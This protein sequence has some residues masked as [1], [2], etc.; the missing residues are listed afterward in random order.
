MHK[1]S[2]L[3]VVLALALAPSVGLLA[4]EV[5]AQAPDAA[6]STSGMVA[7]QQVIASQ[8]GADVLAAG[9][10]A[11]DA[12]IAVGFALAVTHPTA[13]NI[14]GGGFMVIRFPNG[15]STAIDFRE[16]APLAAHPEMWLDESGEYS[17]ELHHRSHMAVGVPGT[18]AGF[19]MAHRLYGQSNWSE[20]VSPAV[21]LAEEGFPLS[22]SLARSISSFGSRS[23]YEATVAAFTKDG[24]AYQ[25]GETWRQPDLARTLARIE[26]GRSDGFYRGETARLIAAEM[27]R[28]GGV[29]T[30]EDLDRYQARERATVTGTYRGFD[31]I[32]MPPPSSGG[33]A[34]VTMLNM[35]EAFDL[36]GMGHNSAAYIHHVSEAMRRAFQDRA[37]YLADSD[38]AD[39]PVQ[40][41][42][43]KEHADWLRRNIDPDRA[44][45]SHPSD[46]AMAPESPE[47]THYSVV[48]EDGLAVSVT[49]TLESGYGSGIVVPGGGFLLN[50]EMGD[51]NAGPGLTNASGLIGTEPNLTRPQQ[52]MLSSMTPSIVAKDGDLVAVVGTPGG[53]TIINTVLQVVLNLID[54]DMGI[55]A[56]VDA[57]RFHHQWLPD[58]ISIEA[59]GATAETVE[60]LE[61]MGHVV[62][63]GGQ[64][65]SANSVGIDAVTGERIG[66]PDPRSPD[67]AARGR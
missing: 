19:D 32:S 15:Q 14:G 37:E 42:T 12:A 6:R 29:I 39:V 33:V 2:S 8:V 11:V 31:I 21:R 36:A 50:N 60:R 55:Q 25:A 22:E 48:D 5:A 47:T 51:F 43:S 57:P 64:Q 23:S 59:D 40:W 26:R 58:R 28:G 9:G 49:Y 63:I 67:A 3:L 66:A 7:S 1:N 4:V 30:E 17:S 44:S 52:R 24:G 20:L 16:K 34:L 54:F 10:N 65:G 27:R 46:V 13:G 61:L 53:R 18:V 41:L 38:F 35:L 56:A 62:R 45:V